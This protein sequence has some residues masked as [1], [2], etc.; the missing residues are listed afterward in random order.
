M[1]SIL[2]HIHEDDC[3]E[4]RFQAAL[5]LGRQFG[6][7]LTCVQA[8]PYEFGVPGDFYGSLA[9]QMATEF[10]EQA[11]RV[12]EQYEA[13]LAKEDVP[14]DWHISDGAATRLIGRYAP[15]ADI[16]VFGA[17]NPAGSPEKP[18]TLVSDLIGTL[19]APMLV[20]P[21]K[22]K[23]F[24]TKAP[25]AIA[26]NGSAEAAHAIA[27]SLPL[28]RQ[29]SE[30]HILTVRESKDEKQ[31]AFPSMSAAEYLARF[32]IEAEIVDIPRDDGGKTSTAH[33][34]MDAAANRKAGFL[35][36]GAYGH[37]RLR[38]RILGG[39]TREL[40]TNPQLPLLLGH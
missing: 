37:S 21:A 36:M 6:G 40:L 17:R 38:E 32:D 4:A 23:S 27:G 19:R 10:H 39:V 8:I 30:V 1:R 34:L 12:R 5:D 25:A 24:Q 31:F 28:L 26:W 7:H 9:A 20:V 2:L 3:L 29:A 16:S 13:R 22:M 14:Y 18:S 15:L 35:V 33:K 11:K